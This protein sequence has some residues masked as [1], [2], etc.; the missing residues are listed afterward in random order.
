[1]E[2]KMCVLDDE[3]ECDGCLECE[4]CDLDP[5]KICD[6]CGKCLNIQ[7]FAAIRIDKVYTDPEEYERD[8]RTKNCP[9]KQC[10]FK[11]S[12]GAARSS[13]SVSCFGIQASN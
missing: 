9:V 12:S 3:K 2:R 7:E 5:N 6:N 4:V 13:G 10:N 8:Y 11:N 1:M